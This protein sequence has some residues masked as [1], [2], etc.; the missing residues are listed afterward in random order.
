MD[1]LRIGNKSLINTDIHIHNDESIINFI[2]QKGENGRKSAFYGKYRI[3]SEENCKLILWDTFKDIYCV[4]DYVEMYNK[5]DLLELVAVE[6]K[7]FL[8]TGIG[9]LHLHPFECPESCNTNKNA[10]EPIPKAQS[11]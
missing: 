8:R 6:N 1:T 9:Q 7:W 3:T 10:P 11:I 5:N 2:L 4:L